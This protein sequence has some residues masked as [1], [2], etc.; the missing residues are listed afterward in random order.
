MYFSGSC[1]TS[2]LLNMAL[3]LH[4]IMVF[5]GI[6]YPPSTMSWSAILFV[7]VSA[8]TILIDSCMH[9]DRTLCITDWKTV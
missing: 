8:G 6:R 3:R 4:Q 1:Q 9:R 7:P 2:G 5:R